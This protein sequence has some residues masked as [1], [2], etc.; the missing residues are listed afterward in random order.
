MITET[1]IRS[2]TNLLIQTGSI[3]TIRSRFAPH[4]KPSWDE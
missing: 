1:I 4:L 2:K 3:Y